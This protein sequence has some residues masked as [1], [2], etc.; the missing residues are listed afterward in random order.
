MK[1]LL[2]THTL[3]WWLYN[4]PRL[5]ARGSGLLRDPDSTIYVSAAS[6]WEISTKF[7]LGKLPSAAVLVQDF[8]GW[9]QKAGFR[10]MS[11][12]IGHAQKAGSWQLAHRDPFDRMLA[13]QSAL[14]QL[15][16]LTSDTALASF[17]VETL[18]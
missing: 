9:I 8:A 1:L 15:P 3:L 5:S 7:R 14:E 10:A 16:L 11:I 4:D 6:V 2:D 12:E 17:G 13:A 18:W